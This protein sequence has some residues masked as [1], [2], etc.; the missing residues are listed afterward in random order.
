MPVRSTIHWSEVSRYFSNSELGT[1]RGGT[2]VPS[3]VIA[4]LDVPH[5]VD[6]GVLAQQ[7]VRLLDDRGALF[8]LLA[9]VEESHL[10]GRPVHDIAHVH[11]AEV[12]KA[13]QLPG[14]AIDIGAGIEHQYGTVNA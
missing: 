3:P 2:A 12:R 5:I 7:P 1:T 6:A 10:R 4:A 13:D 8:F 9:D 14:R 11:G